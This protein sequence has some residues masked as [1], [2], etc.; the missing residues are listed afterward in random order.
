MTTPGSWLAYHYHSI[1]E[2]SSVDVKFQDKAPNFSHPQS[3]AIKPTLH[4]QRLACF[5]W[6]EKYRKQGTLN[7]LLSQINSS[8]PLS[9]ISQLIFINFTV[10]FPFSSIINKDC[11]FGL[12]TTPFPGVS[13]VDDICTLLTSSTNYKLR[14]ELPSFSQVSNIY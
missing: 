8:S 5:S 7:F 9:F 2:N 1:L 6:H 13:V 14:Y 12:G 11:A 10:F 3:L 4:S